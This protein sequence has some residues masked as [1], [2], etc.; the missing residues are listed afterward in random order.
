MSEYDQDMLQSPATDVLRGI[1]TEHRQSQQL[2]QSNQLS[3]PRQ[4]LCL[5]RLDIKNYTKSTIISSN[6]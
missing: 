4:D 2:K 3:L 6:E 5:A 1:D